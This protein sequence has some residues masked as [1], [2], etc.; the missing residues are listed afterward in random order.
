M[1]RI[2]VVG[3]GRVGAVL[4]AAFREAGHDIVAVAGESDASR[5][6]IQTL[7]PG[8]AARKPSA[9]ARA[10]D[11][12]LVAVPDDALRNVVAMLSAAGAI[13]V[14]QYV[15][16]TSGQHG[17]D[18]LGPASERGARVA[19][20]HPAMT[21]TGTELDLPR[22]PATVFGCTGTDHVRPVVEGLVADLRCRAVW[23][24][25]EQ[26][27]RYHAALAHGAN[28]LVTLVQQASELLRGAGV[29][30]PADVVGPLMKAALD[31]ALAYGDAALTGPIARGDVQTVREHL[32]TLAVSSPETLE[33]YVAMGRATAGRAAIDGRLDPAR[34]AAIIGLLDDA[35]LGAR[36]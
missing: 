26:R 5:I 1:A 3:A 6:R 19:A 30:A 31:N 24:D 18:V 8:I 2:G 33:S 4:A 12:L 17:T 32:R 10:A 35:L 28:H 23:V 9:V 22:I 20:M 16:H 7:L 36:S 21:F 25:E 13:H 27:V 14:G 29:D 15:V 11:I 34:A